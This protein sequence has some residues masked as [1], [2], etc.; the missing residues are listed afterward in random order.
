MLPV[1]RPSAATLLGFF[2]DTTKPTSCSTSPTLLAARAQFSAGGGHGAT[3]K[4]DAPHLPCIIDDDTPTPEHARF[5]KSRLASVLVVT[6][7]GFL[8][9]WAQQVLG[10]DALFLG[11]ALAALA[12]LALMRYKVGVVPVIAGC[13]LADLA[14]RLRNQEMTSNVGGIGL[15]TK[16]A[17]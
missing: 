1:S 12:A 13:A 15:G 8:G 5:R 16:V 11:A 7:V 10:P 6:S 4:V 3:R 9:G 17:P 14:L 2:M